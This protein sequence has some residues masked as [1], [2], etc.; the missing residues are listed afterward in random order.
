MGMNRMESAE[1]VRS[2]DASASLP[3]SFCSIASRM[4]ETILYR[5]ALVDSS[6]ADKSLTWKAIDFAEGAR[7]ISALAAC[8]SGIGIGKGSKVAIIAATRGEWM[9]ADMAI[10]SLG[11]VSVS[12]YPSLSSHDMAY[13]LY[14][15]GAEVVFAEN[16]EQLSKLTTMLSTPSHIPE[17]EERSA[18]EWQLSL[19]KII[20]FERTDAHELVTHLEDCLAEHKLKD[21]AQLEQLLVHGPTRE[22][23]ASLVYTSGTTG[24]PKGVMQT[25]ANHLANIRQSFE[26]GV[27]NPES[28]IFLVLPLAHSFAKLIG[29]LGFLSP[30]ELTISAVAD[31]KTSRQSPDLFTTCMREAEAEIIP[32]VPRLLEKLYEGLIAASAAKNLSGRILTFT[33]NA[34]ARKS[35]IVRNGGQVPFLVNVV[36]ALTAGI[37]RKISRRLFGSRL[38]FLVSGGAK[39]SAEV[40]QFFNGLEIATVEGYGLTETVVAC[41]VGRVGETPVGSVGPILGTGI[42][43]RIAADGE[44]YIK[45]PNVAQGY[46]NRPTATKKSWN[47]EGWFMTGDLGSIDEH[48][49]L[50]ITGRKK[51]LIVTSGG[52]NIAPFAMEEKLKS[53]PL[54]SQA[55]LIGDGRKYCTAL[56]TLNIDEAMRLV[57]A[58]DSHELH[59]HPDIIKRIKEH[60]QVCNEGLASFETVKS[61]Y[62]APENFTIDNGLLTP[63][64]K[65]KR[66]A[67]EAKYHEAI[68]A[69]YAKTS[70]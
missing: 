3:A 70:V 42:E 8:L 56:V 29:Y 32:V 9:L 10:L 19:K 20:T 26:S 62:I 5:Q 37:R 53:L 25:H 7:A 55:I 65:I 30:A 48:G 54:I 4:P 36:F 28:R 39:L 50:Y 57:K 64:F 22:D 45:G 12:V 44:L 14:D 58:S 38:K 60:M 24:P 69:L 34:A 33:L 52:K 18:L 40:S 68:D 49:N 13:I 1:L 67:V 23:L 59:M 35:T 16:Q 61:I 15:S 46:Y 31:T 43:L 63:S 27:F 21:L 2:L 11:A 66:A 51:E 17:T 41:T 47:E 6:S